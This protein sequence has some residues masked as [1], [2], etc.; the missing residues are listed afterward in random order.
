MLTKANILQTSLFSIKKFFLAT[1]LCF[2]FYYGANFI[3]ELYNPDWF[4]YE[5]IFVDGSHLK[6]N[7][8]D[9]G[10]LAII[11]GFKLFSNSYE[12]FR[13]TLALFFS[14][15][16]FQLSNGSILKYSFKKNKLIV[17]LFFLVAFLF[18]RFTIQIREGLA[19]CFVISALA[20]LLNNDTLTINSSKAFLKT[21]NL[22]IFL[23]FLIGITIHSG[24]LT[25]FLMFLASFFIKEN[26]YRLKSIY[27]KYNRTILYSILVFAI[28][29]A[30]LYKGLIGYVYFLQEEEQL[31]ST[32]VNLAKIGYWVVNGILTIVLVAQLKNY[33]MIVKNIQLKIYLILMADFL[34]PFVFTLTFTSILLSSPGGLVA[35]LGRIYN[36][37]L[38]ISLLALCFKTKGN[39]LFILLLSLFII[40]DQARIVIESLVMQEF[41]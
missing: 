14:G 28:I 16:I 38:G 18:I 41:I 20:N 23:Y 3:V 32:E 17:S 36:L 29:V 15:F 13:Y 35:A 22:K 6:D 34:L 19:V 39:S 9:L 4:I 24:V 27:K 37:A 10:F 31:I 5:L 30:F 25:F 26:V 33:A 7:G 11:A 21:I 2:V 12:L 8:R 40:V 1:I